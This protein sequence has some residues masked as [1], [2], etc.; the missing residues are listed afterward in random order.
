MLSHRRFFLL[1]L[2][3]SALL[4]WPS[5]SSFAE[6][7]RQPVV[8]LIGDSTVR[9]GTKGQ[10]GWGE[11][12]APWVD[13]RSY[14]VTN[15]A[16]GGRSSRTF[17]TEGRWEEVRSQIRKGDFLLV[18][19]GHNDNGPLDRDRARGSL[20]GTG[21]E[22]KDVVVEATGK[23]E[24]VHTF[25]WY[26]RQYA[27]EGREAGA[28]VV[29]FSLVPR[30]LWKDGKVVRSGDGHGRWTREAAAA[31]GAVF[32]D[33]NEIVAASYEKLGGEKTNALFTEADHTHTSEAG[34][35]HTAALVA[36][37][38]RKARLPGLSAAIRTSPQP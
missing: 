30:N 7:A 18:Q 31:T 12:L 11:C 14:T 9:N 34:A 20:K 17:R 35:R 2:C 37:E 36:A 1:S 22:T 24:T 19:F 21:E 16:I 33:L 5:A 38:L 32:I 25:G 10:K 28:T 26:L 4:V 6:E 3:T 23:P 8:W 15:K 29:F 27:K 13:A